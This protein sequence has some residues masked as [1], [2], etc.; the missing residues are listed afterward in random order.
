MITKELITYFRNDFNEIKKSLEEK[1]NISINLGNSSFDSTSFK[2]KMNVFEIS[3]D[4]IGKSSEQIEFEKNCN[5]FKFNIMNIDKNDY[6]RKLLLSDNITIAK[7][8]GLKNNSNKYPFIV[9][10]NNKRYKVTRNGLIE[11]FKKF[12]NLEIL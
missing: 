1:Y 4:D 10:A 2:I 11:G 12:D 3:K 8:V 9:Q 7:L 6:G 5:L